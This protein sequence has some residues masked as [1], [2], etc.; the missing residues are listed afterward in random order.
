MASNGE[1]RHA[2]W[3]RRPCCPNSTDRAARWGAK[4]NAGQR[5]ANK[6]GASAPG[7]QISHSCTQHHGHAPRP[8]MLWHH[9]AHGRPKG[10]WPSE[11]FTLAYPLGTQGTTGATWF[12][13]WPNTPAW[14][15]W[16]STVS[17]MAKNGVRRQAHWRR[18]RYCPTRWIARWG[19]K[20]QH[21]P[22]QRQQRRDKRAA[23]QISHRRSRPCAKTRHAMAPHSS[24]S[25]QGHICWHRPRRISFVALNGKGV[26]R[27]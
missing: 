7:H 15:A 9:N 24:R 5:S 27:A 19:G 25:A 6:G 3:R 11:L 14:A 21:G 10:Q 23:Y 17:G 20:E 26:H 13:T 18:R 16:P 1:R 8:D 2:H 12:W 22:T 4:S